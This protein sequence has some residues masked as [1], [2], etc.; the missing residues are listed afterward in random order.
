MWKIKNKIV[1]P[2]RRE[3]VILKDCKREDKGK[4]SN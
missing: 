3:K 1:A 2:V 4:R